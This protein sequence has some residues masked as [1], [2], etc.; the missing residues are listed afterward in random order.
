MAQITIDVET[1]VTYQVEVEISDEDFEAWDNGELD[2][3]DLLDMYEDEIREVQSDF[4]LN[5]GDLSSE[6]WVH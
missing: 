4:D 6:L 5:S 2:E 3:A 1:K